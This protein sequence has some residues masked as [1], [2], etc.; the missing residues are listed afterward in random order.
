[1]SKLIASCQFF[2][3]AVIQLIILS[4]DCITQTGF[5]LA[6]RSSDIFAFIYLSTLWP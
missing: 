6:E 3:A 1:M 4:V 2:L 5:C